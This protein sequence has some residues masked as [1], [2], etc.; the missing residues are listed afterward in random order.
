MADSKRTLIPGA[1]PLARVPAPLVF[2]L[3][4][5]LFG[6][7][8]WLRGTVGAV[9]LGVLALGVAALLAST[10]QFLAPSARVLRVLVLAVLVLVTVSVL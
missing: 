4:L 6:T 2:L 10:W 3:V 9:L 1:G 8:V 5:A 7:G